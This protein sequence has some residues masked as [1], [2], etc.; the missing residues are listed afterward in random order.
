[1]YALLSCL[2]P[3]FVS[4]SLYYSCRNGT[5]IKKTGCFLLLRSF[6]PPFLQISSFRLIFICTLFLDPGACCLLIF[7]D[8]AGRNWVLIWCWNI[9]F[10]RRS[11]PFFSSSV[12]SITSTAKLNGRTD[13]YAWNWL[14]PGKDNVT[15]SLS[16]DSLAALS[17]SLST[18]LLFWSISFRRFSSCD[19]CK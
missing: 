8:A 11:A 1:M 16:A 2:L 19:S 15:R 13:H 4:L 10:L 5:T 12:Q 18:L 17:F 7:Y 14:V 9:S 3:S 6:L